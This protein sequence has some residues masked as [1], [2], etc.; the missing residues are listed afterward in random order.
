[1]RDIRQ[2]PDGYLSGRREIVVR[3]GR[4]KA[5]AVGIPRG[6]LAEMREHALRAVTGGCRKLQ[7]EDTTGREGRML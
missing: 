3:E 4:G 2:R 1:M 7:G 6:A 5:W